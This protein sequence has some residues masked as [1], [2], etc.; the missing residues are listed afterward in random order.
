MVVDV[1]DGRVR[2][3]LLHAAPR[4]LQVSGVEEERE[5]RIAAMRRLFQDFVEARQEFVHLGQR[6]WNQHRRLL[7]GGAK[8]LRKGQAAAKRV[9]IRVLMTEDEDLLVGVDEVSDLIELVV[10]AGLRGGYGISSLGSVLTTAGGRT[11][12]RSSAVWTL[13]LLA[14]SSSNRR[15]GENLRFCKRRPSSWRITP[16]ADT[17]P[18]MDAFFSSGLP[19]TLTR[20]R[21]WRRSGDMRTAVMLTKPIR[22]SLRSRRMIDMISSRTC[23]PT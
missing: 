13:Y 7:A 5:K 18:A 1:D 23:S 22:G 11:S 16:L 20:T 15:S 6:R 2:R 8:R 4:P 10:D 3:D 12:F 21:A 9:P 14:G 17:R 19:S